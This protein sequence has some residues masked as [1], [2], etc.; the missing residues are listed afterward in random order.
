MGF[1]YICIQLKI[2]AMNIRPV[3]FD[4]EFFRDLID[5]KDGTNEQAKIFSEFLPDSPSPVNQF[6]YDVGEYVANEGGVIFYRWFSDVAYGQAKSEGNFQN[7]LVVDMNDLPGSFQYASLNA[8]IPGAENS[9]DGFQNTVDLI[10]A[11]PTFGITA[12]VAADQCINNTSGGKNDWYLPSIY[13]LGKLASN[14]FD[15]GGALTSNGGFGFGISPY[16]SSTE[17]SQT[18]AQA[19]RFIS[20]QYQQVTK[21]NSISVRAIRRFNI[22]TV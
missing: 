20:N 13:E 14:V 5:Y 2:Q 1:F 17:Y 12:G 10:A 18:Q 4:P 19:F 11:G 22:Q 15:I 16:W 8:F 3:R 9:W 21:L 6:Q 7:Y